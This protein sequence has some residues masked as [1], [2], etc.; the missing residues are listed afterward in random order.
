MIYKAL[1]IIPAIKIVIN[2]VARTR[3]WV[4]NTV[5]YLRV[6]FVNSQNLKYGD[7]DDKY[8]KFGYECGGVFDKNKEILYLRMNHIY[9]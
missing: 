7:A 6:G 9:E 5:T 3:V 8:P 2:Y 4:S 1:R